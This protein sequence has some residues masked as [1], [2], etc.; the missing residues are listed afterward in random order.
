MWRYPPCARHLSEQKRTCSQSRA[1]FLR[2]ANGRLQVAQ[3]LSG[4]LAFAWRGP[5]A[6]FFMRVKIGRPGR[7]REPLVAEPG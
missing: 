6:F 2:H 3:I 4:R 5:F 1:H 7:E